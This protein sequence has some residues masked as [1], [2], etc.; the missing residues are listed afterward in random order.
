M[1][2]A[3]AV[4]IMAMFATPD[5][6]DSDLVIRMP[7]Q[8]TQYCEGHGNTIVMRLWHNGNSCLDG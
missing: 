8:P 2:G 4:A 3:A 5:Q 6:S 7:T 1:S